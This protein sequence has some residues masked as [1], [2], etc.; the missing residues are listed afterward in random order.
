MASTGEADEGGAE[1][2][3]AIKM[4]DGESNNKFPVLS[5]IAGCDWLGD[6]R[7]VGTDFRVNTKLLLK[8]G[9]RYDLQ[10]NEGII[11][12]SSFLT[13]PNGKTRQVV[14]RGSQSGSLKYRPSNTIRLDPVEPENGP[15]FM[16]LTELSPDT[17][18]LNEV[19]KASEKTIMTASL[20]IVD[21]GKELVQVS[22]EVGEGPELSI[23]GHQIW[24]LKK[25][26][27]SDYSLDDDGI[28]KNYREATGV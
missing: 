28:E 12:L 9:V 25:S 10:E 5:Q 17:L 21:E 22:H 1:N 24:R 4:K 20:S 15:I 18:L 26:R 11:T 19:D 13:F 14:M 6:C 27:R 3:E 8:G 2:V 7:Y 16:L 23:E